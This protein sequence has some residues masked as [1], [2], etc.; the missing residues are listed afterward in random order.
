MWCLECLPFSR[1]QLRCRQWLLTACSVNDTLVEVVPFLT[2]SFFQMINVTIPAAVQL[3]L[4]MPQIVAGDQRK[5][6]TSLS[7]EFSYYF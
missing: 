6:L 1:I 2:E 4:K 3:L 5:Q 7:L